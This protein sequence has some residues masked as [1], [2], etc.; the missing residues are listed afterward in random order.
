MGLYRGDRVARDLRRVYFDRLRTVL[1][2]P[3]RDRL[4]RELLGDYPATR[5][6]FNRFFARYQAYR[7][8]IQPEQGEPDLITAELRALWH[9]GADMT[10]TTAR[11]LELIDLHVAYAWRHLGDLREVASDLP[12]ARETLV[13]RAEDSIRPVSGRRT[14]TTTT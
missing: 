3:S 2:R 7:M 4:E 9:G 12:R 14:S 8:L 1:L 6:A 13:Q 11:Q 10:E 5:E